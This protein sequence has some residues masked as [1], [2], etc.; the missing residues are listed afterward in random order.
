M[1]DPVFSRRPLLGVCLCFILGIVFAQGF[2]VPGAILFILT[3]FLLLMSLRA[4]SATLSTVLLLSAVMCVGT[5]YFR[6]YQILPAGH[7]GRMPSWARQGSVLAEGV[8]VSDA[9]NRDFFGREKTVFVL[10]LKRVQSKQGWEGNRGRVLVNL[11]RQESVRYGDYLILEGILH[12]PF[13]FSRGGRFSYREYLARQGIV[14]ILSVKKTGRLEKLKQ[15][16]GHVLLEGVFHFKHQLRRILKENLPAEAA[17]IMQ[18]FLLGDRSGIPK[19]V[20]ANFQFSG[21]AHIIAISGFNIGIVAYGILFFL[22]MFPIPRQG[23][24]LLTVALLIFYAVLT[25]GQPSV[26][27][28]TIMAVVFLIGLLVEREPDPLN[29][30]ALAA[31]IILLINP[32]NIYDVGFQ[33]SFNSVLAIYVLY[34]RILN[35]V[36]KPFPGLGIASGTARSAKPGTAGGLRCFQTFGMRYL[37]QPMALSGAVYVFVGPLIAYYFRLVT[38]VV[39]IANIVIVPVASMMIYLGLGLLLVGGLCPFLAF[40]FANCLVLLLN[41]MVAS[42]DFFAGIP[43]AYIELNRVPLWG[44]VLYYLL[45]L[46]GFVCGCFIR[47]CRRSRV[48]PRKKAKG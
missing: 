37:L 22:K 47:L 48:C 11:F 1:M 40:S 5:G 41:F 6:N 12:R 30:L 32:W 17:G 13:N 20:Y 7:V 26:V 34:P 44:V 14:F 23:Q 16:R 46:L 10:D 2:Q 42:V 28:A 35:F 33:L 19:E 36:R 8:V 15:G 9:E 21:V 4:R 29:S 31:F 18:A 45:L 27:R 24:Y 38:P 3:V 25:G 39:M 43:G